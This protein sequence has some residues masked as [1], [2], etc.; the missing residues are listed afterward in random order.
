MTCTTCDF[1]FHGPLSYGSLPQGYAPVKGTRSLSL[2]TTMLFESSGRPARAESGICGE[3]SHA[4]SLWIPVS[5][6]SV[7]QHRCQ[8]VIHFTLRR[9]TILPHISQLTYNFALCY[10]LVQPE[11]ESRHL[12]QIFTTIKSFKPSSSHTSIGR[13][14]LESLGLRTTTVSTFELAYFSGL[15]ILPQTVRSSNT[16]L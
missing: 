9:D 13:R 3:Q 14:S 4:A 16:S 1:C 12:L 11:L 5:L 6:L 8:S 2:V 15:I 7:Y 10:T